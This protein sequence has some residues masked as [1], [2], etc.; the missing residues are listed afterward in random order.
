MRY[1]LPFAIILLLFSGALG[2]FVALHTSDPFDFARAKPATPNGVQA[3]ETFHSPAI[4]VN[5]LKGDPRAGEKIFR[6]FCATCHAKTPLIDVHA[7]RIN[8]KK[9]WDAR[10][11]M[12]MAALLAITANGVAAMPARGGCFEC[13]DAQLRATIQYILDQTD[14]S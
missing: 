4:F 6:E 8:D 3:I 5:Q 10:R 7:P 2:V 1:F 9:A 13:S 14:A 12:G 11:R